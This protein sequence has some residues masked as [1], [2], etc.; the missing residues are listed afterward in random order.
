[1]AIRYILTLLTLDDNPQG[2]QQNQHVDKFQLQ[3]YFNQKLK[4]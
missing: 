1:M 3:T 2:T 4:L